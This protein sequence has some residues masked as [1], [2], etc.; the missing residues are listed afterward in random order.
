[1]RI[2]CNAPA[3]API[4]A[5]LNAKLAADSLPHALLLEGA[6]VAQRKD[7]ALALGRALL[8]RAGNE[9]DETDTAM[10]GGTSLFGAPEAPAEEKPAQVPC[11]ACPQCYKTAE[12]IHPDFKV[13]EGGA[14][15]RSLHI[16]AVRAL[17]QEAGVLPNEADRKVFVLLGAHTMTAEAQNALLKLL[18]EPP[19][20]LCLILT[21]P[22]AK[23][24]LQT[25]VSR[26]TALS[27]GP[28]R[29]EAADATRT[30]QVESIAQTLAQTLAQPKNAYA[31][32]EATAPL[33]GDKELLRE[34][35]PATRRAL[36]AL[37][38]QTPARAPR[39]IP[40]MDS[41][42]ALETAL[43]RNANLNLLVTRLAA[44]GI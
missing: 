18:E 29:E 22:Q 42:S 3:L 26:V 23:M 30:A 35:L 33:E 4:A 6:A 20:Y 21:A 28:L 5:L 34:T 9:P 43:E 25:V 13:V 11:E 1:M 14:G 7:A 10:F 44:L 40:L 31:L 17:R 19:P 36:H 2:E 15:A 32:L 24:L 12:G 37:L 38:R 16:D 39:I 8:C 27:L 41:L